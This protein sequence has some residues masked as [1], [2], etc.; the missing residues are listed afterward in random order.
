MNI[1]GL[2]YNTQRERLI[3]PEYGREIQQMVDYAVKL[4]DRAE[5]QRCAEAIIAVMK[6]MFPEGKEMENHEQKL[7]DHL[8]IMSN[9]QLDI[10]YP[11]DVAGAVQMARKPEPM[12]YPM[13]RIPVRHYGAMMFQI[14]NKLK[15]MEPGKERDELVALTANQMHRNLVQWSHGSSDVEKVASDLARFTDGK[16]QLDLDSFVFDKITDHPA[17]PTGQKKKK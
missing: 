6:R 4:E 12:P 5:R 11:F 15:T 7:W 9:F 8:A 16:I 10:D 3:L 13:K 14:F 17:R 1:E 2:D